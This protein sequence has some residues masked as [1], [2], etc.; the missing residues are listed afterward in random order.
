MVFFTCVSREYKSLSLLYEYCIKRVYPKATVIVE[1]IRF[2]PACH[3]FLMCPGKDYV[4]ITDADILIL[5]HKLT[6]EEYYSQFCVDGACYLR[7][8]TEASGKEW[9]EDNER[10]CG[11]HVGFYPEWYDRTAKY[12][13]DYLTGA[14]EDYREFDEVMLA[15]IMKK[16]GYPIPEKAYTFPD[17]SRWDWEYRDLHLGDFQSTKFMKWKPDKEKLR[18]LF[19]EPEFK[20]LAE[21]VD[22]FFRTMIKVATEYANS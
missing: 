13:L 6:H 4:H 20:R 8:A 7:G 1:N 19:A 9:K 14:I 3:R 21:D 22:S 12:R 2:N 10:I 15:R 18:E 16:A 11:G 17:G 5:P